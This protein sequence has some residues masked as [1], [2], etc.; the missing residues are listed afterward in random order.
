MRFHPSAGLDEKIA[1][2]AGPAMRK[3]GSASWNTH[4]CATESMV[5][6]FQDLDGG[7]YYKYGQAGIIPVSLVPSGNPQVYVTH[8]F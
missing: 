2:R 3:T 5:I 4:T 6:H 7:S 8:S 1:A